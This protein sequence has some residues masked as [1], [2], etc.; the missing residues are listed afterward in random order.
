MADFPV[1]PVTIVERVVDNRAEGAGIHEITQLVIIIQALD[2]VQVEV[3]RT[4]DV[5][6]DGARRQVLAVSIVGVARV[7]GLQINIASVR[8]LYL[9][10][11]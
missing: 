6:V 5:L 4:V 11:R 10:R 7:Q 8:H 1:N 2:I 9:D 3:E